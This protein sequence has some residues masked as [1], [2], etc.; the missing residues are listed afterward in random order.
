MAD[1]QLGGTL[2]E[3]AESEA[4][5]AAADD[6]SDTAGPQVAAKRARIRAKKPLIIHAGVHRTGT[7][8]IQNALADN[9]EA[10][11]SNGIS[12]PIDF[13]PVGKP[14]EGFLRSK[15]HLNLAW[16]LRRKDV[17]PDQI[18]EWLQ[19]AT[20]GCWKVILSAEDFCIL[21]DLYFLEPLQEFYEVEVVF[22]LR[23][24]D[25]WINSWYNQHIRWP[26]DETLSATTPLQFLN[27]LDRFPWIRYHDMLERWGAALGREKVRVR[28]F[29]RGQISDV[30][31][32]LFEVSGAPPPNGDYRT[33]ESAPA[34][35]LEFLRRLRLFKL[36]TAA[37]MAVLDAL[38]R[39]GADGGTNVYPAA[40]RRMLL[41]R[42][43]VQNQ[44]VARDYLGRADGILFRD[45]NF[46]DDI[47]NV[48][49]AG[50]LDEAMLLQFI[51]NLIEVTTSKRPNRS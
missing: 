38:E 24:Q 5:A 8:A 11:A 27:H 20:Q 37:R 12:Y 16:S 47:P 2:G 15:S 32:D 28:V 13:A 17:Q 6:A 19:S 50:E 31:A 33:N 43:L 1:D 45:T 14:S 36:P 39:I 10:L 34:S 44:R 40:I 41:Q 21:E 42:Y 25:D 26:F 3:S 48:D 23:R 30:V 29:E 7:T 46:P 49:G 51:G 35:Q 4:A 18:K 22:Y 9:R